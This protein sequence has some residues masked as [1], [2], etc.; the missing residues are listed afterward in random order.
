MTD[1][2]ARRTYYRAVRPTHSERELALLAFG[3]ARK[4]GLRFA[5][6]EVEVHFATNLHETRRNGEADWHGTPIVVW[7]QSGLIAREVIRVVLH[8]LV[9]AYD[10]HHEPTYNDWS[11][12][13]REERCH[14]VARD[15]MAWESWIVPV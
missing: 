1:L 12:E 6:G 14:R 11:I 8:E 10:A 15:V 5:P 3:I 2:S 13:M 9:H 4:H 7:I